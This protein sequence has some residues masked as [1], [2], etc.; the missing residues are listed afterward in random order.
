[1]TEPATEFMSGDYRGPLREWVRNNCPHPD[2]LLKKKHGIAR[3][4]ESLSLDL[5][6][7][8]K[9][10]LSRSKTQEEIRGCGK[11]GECQKHKT[12]GEVR[13]VGHYCN[14][15]SFHVP[16]SI[17]YRAGQGIELRNQYLE[18]AKAQDLWGFWS[19]TFTLP[20]RVRKW[21]DDHPEDRKKFLSDLRR[22]VARTIKASLGLTTHAR[23]VQPGFS[24]MYHPASSGNPF[25]QSSHF[26]SISLPLLADLKG[27]TVQKFGKVID[28]ALV[29]R[30]YKR[31]LDRVLQKWA[32]DLLEE[33]SYVVHLEWID[34]QVESSVNHIFKYNNRSQAFDVLKRVQRISVGLDRF[35]C[36]LH[37]KAQ[38]VYIPT[39]KSRAEMLD[40]L[41]LTMCP[42]IQLRMSYGFMRTLEQYADLLWIERDEHEQ[43][44]NWE[45]LFPV[46]I[47]RLWEPHYDEE[48]K[49]VVGSM[50]LLIRRKGEWETLARLRPDELGG[51]RACMVDRK[52]FKAKGA[53]NG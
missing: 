32:L 3:M 12:S 2:D 7:R 26:H 25:E 8:R 4:M 28:H 53:S 10:G 45:P 46:E 39:I 37:D 24:I 50:V 29:K 22:G 41:E 6:Q 16:C 38:D 30:I 20:L 11:T 27:K 21:I 23:K 17:R 5:V 19:W 48:R 9:H 51:E 52:I 33:P 34:R 36:V 13:Y 43:E 44:E 18:V 15:R 42:P 31:E 49:K 47:I 40:A 1:M 35:V 14:N